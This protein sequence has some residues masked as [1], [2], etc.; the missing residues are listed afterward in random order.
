[1]KRIDQVGLVKGL[2]RARDDCPARERK[3][4]GA[5]KVIFTGEFIRK[6]AFVRNQRKPLVDNVEMAIED[7]D[8]IHV[9]MR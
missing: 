6:E 4:L 5:G 7:P 8:E 9:C 3:A 1:M 2:K